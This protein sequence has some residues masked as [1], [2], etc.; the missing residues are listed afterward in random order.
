VTAVAPE[1]AQNRN[2]SASGTAGRRYLDRAVRA[3]RDPG[4]PL[5]ATWIRA[6]FA[7]R[8]FVVWVV[9]ASW[10]VA[11]GAYSIHHGLMG[12]WGIFPIAARML[13]SGGPAGGFHFYFQR[14]DFQFG[15]VA[16]LVA[17]PLAHLP[18]LT[19]KWVAGI[20]MTVC[21]LWLVAVISGITSRGIGL[22]TPGPVLLGGL[23]V[24]P[25]WASLT[26]SSGHLDDVLALGFGL[27]GILQVRR[28]KPIWAAVFLALA[29]DSKPWAV[30]F[31]V[32][33]IALPRP[34]WLRS[35]L[36]WAGLIVVAWL[37][38]FI[39]EPRTFDAMKYKLLISPGSVLTIFDVTGMS[40]SWIRPAQLLLALTVGLIVV[41]AGAP[42][43][44][45]LATVASRILLD[46]E[47]AAYYTAGA[48]LVAYIVDRSRAE[49]IP[50][51]TFSAVALLWL[52]DLLAVEPGWLPYAR[53]LRLLWAVGTLV[54][55]V[56]TFG[57]RRLPGGQ[58]Q[59]TPAAPTGSSVSG[60]SGRAAVI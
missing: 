45:L 57:S 6:L 41:R 30:A 1:P 38:F 16:S 10:T 53:W 33:L 26:L 21:G 49:K 17:A 51:F 50:W 35:V 23:M 52:P 54:G 55:L 32:A 13:L 39:V 7:P 14:P 60:S 56:A 42:Q 27:F 22:P 37:P 18:L 48:V 11:W 47:I 59:R 19:S 5:S 43:A 34:Q 4:W 9:L 58:P 8:L 20:L 15:P 28:G 44:V 2:P 40:P 36:V 24:M 31:A 3:L 25:A 12:S 29:V 46:P